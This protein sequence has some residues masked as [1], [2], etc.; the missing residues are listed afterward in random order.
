[1]KKYDTFV[2]C[3][4]DLFELV[5]VRRSFHLP[6]LDLFAGK[7]LSQPGHEILASNN[8]DRKVLRSLYD[9]F[10][11]R[12]PQLFI[13]GTSYDYSTSIDRLSNHFEHT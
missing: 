2:H 6:D 9:V 5:N 13:F 4:L 3:L 10:K 7:L 8:D 11:A 1:M 12:D